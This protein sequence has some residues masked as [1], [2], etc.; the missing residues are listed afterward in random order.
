[1]KVIGEGVVNIGKCCSIDE[2][3][4]ILFKGSQS[5]VSIA[6]YVSIGNDVKII[7][8]GGDVSIGEWSTVHANSLLLCKEYLTIGQHCWFG[9]NSILDGTGG[10]HMEDGVRVGMYSQIWTHVAAG[11]QIE[12]CKLFS[13]R[14]TRICKDVWLVGSCTVGSGIEIG[15]RAICM[16]G[17]NIT[18]SIPSNATA[19]GSPAKVR[20]GLSFYKNIS[21]DEKFELMIEWAKNFITEKGG[22]LEIRDS[23]IAISKENQELLVCKT[24]SE[25]ED[26][27][28]RSAE[29][30]LFCIETKKYTKKYS[31]L[32]EQFIRFLSGNKARFY[33]EI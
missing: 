4:T 31:V 11:E 10:L 14:P 8:E 9:Q 25:F 26:N 33:S 15:A 29:C 2:S 22:K 16:N 5:K 18:K 28:L 19:M 20:E 17:S 3:V 23:V 30:V 7:V 1:M 27:M 13:A 21:L 12:G 24:K 32:E 6:D